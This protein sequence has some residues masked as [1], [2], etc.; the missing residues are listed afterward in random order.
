MNEKRSPQVAIDGQPGYYIRRLHQISVAIFLQE[1]DAFGVTPVQYAA[2]QVVG[3]Q[4]GIDQRT[5]AGAIGLDVSTIGGVVNRLESRG[6]LVRSTTAED[7]R[8]RQLNLTKAG[9]DLL[10]KIVPSML[11]AQQLILKPLNKTERAEFLRMLRT[12]VDENNELSRAPS[13]TGPV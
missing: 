12:L 3:D 7:R 2:L 5:L 10:V 13:V 11:K 4:P 9:R 8:V 1:T 6:L